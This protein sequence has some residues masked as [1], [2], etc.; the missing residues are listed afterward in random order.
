MTVPIVIMTVLSVLI[1]L[2]PGVIVD[3][4]MNAVQVIV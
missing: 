1:G 4:I 2:F 3:W